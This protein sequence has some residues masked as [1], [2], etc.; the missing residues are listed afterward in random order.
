MG[1]P[2]YLIPIPPEGPLCD[3]APELRELAAHARAKG[4][5][6]LY[7]PRRFGKTS[8]VRRVQSELAA[9]G[10]VTV[11]CDLF[12]VASVE[13]AAARLA[14]AVFAQVHGREPLWKRALATLRTFRPVLR[15]DP[16]GGASLTVEP[17]AAG[18]SGMALLSE[19]ME[20]LVAFIADTD[21]LVHIALDEFQEIVMLKEAASVEAE[22]R[23]G[24]AQTRAA[25]LFVGSRRHLL[26]G[27]FSERQRPFFQSAV[28][29]PLPPLPD[30]ELQ[31]YARERFAAGGHP[32]DEAAAARLAA[33]AAGHPYYAQR[34]G[35]FAWEIAEREQREIGATTLDTAFAELLQAETPVYE[36]IVSALTLQ[37]RLLLRALAREP[38]PQIM[39]AGYLQ[40]HRLGSVGGIQK[41]IRA[42]RELDLAERDDDDEPWRLT[43]AMLARWLNARAEDHLA[44]E[45][46]PAA[47]PWPENGPE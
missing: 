42:L 20:T 45:E 24:I 35:Y 32:C 10:A 43:D 28:L 46:P 9:E 5:V 8:L 4:S 17:V 38:S 14:R 1:N 44:E 13:D 31:V 25:W 7:S 27:L 16:Q 21:E 18:R 37:Q 3:R 12:G 2:F 22:L 36:A 19:V 40:R 23:A 30:K 26:L 47:E 33:L 29:R 11:F 39:A 41:S 15:P 6:V 34:L